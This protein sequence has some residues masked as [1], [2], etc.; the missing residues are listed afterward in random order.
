MIIYMSKV[1]CVTNRTLCRDDF[2]DRIEALCRAKPAGIILR[3]K[4]LSMQ[5]YQNLAVS[6]LSVC[7]Y[8][9]VPCILHS[10]A[11]VAVD[12]KADRLHLPLSLLEELSPKV[13]MSLSTLGASCHSVQDAKK[14]QS[15]GC[16]YITAGHIFATDCKKGLPPRGL[17]FLQQ[18]CS[19]VAIP[20]YAIGGIL[21]A[22]MPSILEAGAA[23]VCIMSSAM[24]CHNVQAY[25]K[26]FE[27]ADKTH[28]I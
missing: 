1:L 23:G 3:E 18:I 15:L 26:E 20:V 5:E 19:S 12:L 9:N 25:F 17:D 7:N 11:Q 16:T 8:Y 10:F 21:P 28:E 24:T 13:R 22:K 14:A 27:K 4:D 6:V 2:L